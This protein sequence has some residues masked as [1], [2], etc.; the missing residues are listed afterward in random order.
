M[1]RACK[2]AEQQARRLAKMR[3]LSQR[4]ELP[5]FH[6]KQQVSGFRFKPASLRRPV[7]GK[8]KTAL[9]GHL[10]RGGIS[11]TS[12]CGRNTAGRSR[13]PSAACGRLRISAAADIPAADENQSANIA[14]VI[15]GQ[16]NETRPMLGIG[17]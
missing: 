3:Q 8:I 9:R 16:G 13:Q 10:N 15:G 7:P 17:Q 4:G 2:T 1:W 11:F 5:D 6:R 12:L 14:H